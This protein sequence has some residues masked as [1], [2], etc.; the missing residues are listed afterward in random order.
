LSQPLKKL[1]ERLKKFKNS[2][3]MSKTGV[4]ELKTAAAARR[5]AKND[6]F[7]GRADRPASRTP[8]RASQTG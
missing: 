2:L 8:G 5:W 1:P 4:W 7:E 6:S 3:K